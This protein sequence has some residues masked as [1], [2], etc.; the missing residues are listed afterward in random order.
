LSTIAIEEAEIA[1]SSCKKRI[2]FVKWVDAN[3]A[4]PPVDVKRGFIKKEANP[5]HHNRAQARLITARVNLDLHQ[6][7]SKLQKDSNSNL[8]W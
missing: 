4:V 8:I 7:R 2:I 5:V 1:K 3:M 6:S